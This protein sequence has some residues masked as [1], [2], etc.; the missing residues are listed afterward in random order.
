MQ[1]DKCVLYVLSLHE[2][3]L[4]CSMVKFQTNHMLKD[5]YSLLVSLQLLGLK[6][7]VEFCWRL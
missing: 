4:M 2:D 1:L 3:Q 6:F 5:D 7:G